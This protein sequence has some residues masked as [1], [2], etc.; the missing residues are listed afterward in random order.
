VS[1]KVDGSVP[2]AAELLAS[3][4]LRDF[5]SQMFD[6]AATRGNVSGQVQLG[7]PLRPDLPPGSTDYDI[8]VDLTNFSAD[9]MLF[10]QKVEAQSLHITATNQVY[11]I[12]GDVKIAGAPAQVDYRKLKGE[13][14][15]EVKVAAT[16]DEA[17][18]TRFGLD[19][20]PAL[21]G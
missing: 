6:P 16:L 1:F 4:R 9:K 3:D 10:G 18:R 15:A 14:D 19:V 5:S 21:A 20:G 12:K 13:T 11:E 7:M 17:A 2:A 8:T